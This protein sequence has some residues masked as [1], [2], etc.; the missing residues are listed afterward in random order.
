MNPTEHA[1]PLPGPML[2][3]LPPPSLSRQ[4]RDQ[5]RMLAEF[6]TQP[7]HRACVAAEPGCGE[8]VIPATW[9]AAL[10]VEG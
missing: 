6:A 5:L 2:P 1:T 10:L 8:V 3:S 7:G 4:R 9:L